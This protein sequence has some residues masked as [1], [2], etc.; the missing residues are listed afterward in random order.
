MHY[1]K[2]CRAYK[3]GRNFYCAGAHVIAELISRDH[4]IQRVMRPEVGSIFL[5]GRQAKRVSPAS[6]AGRVRIIF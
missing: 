3:P 1:Q 2:F 4:I 5:S 6:T